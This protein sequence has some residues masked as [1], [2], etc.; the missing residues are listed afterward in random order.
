[1]FRLFILAGSLTISGGKNYVFD[2]DALCAIAGKNLV[3]W[4]QREGEK[5]S[6]ECKEEAQKIS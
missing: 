1:M 3:Q 6:F 2:T 4:Y 5:V